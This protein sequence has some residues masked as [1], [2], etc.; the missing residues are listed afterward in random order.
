MN[1]RM[2]H[3][4]REDNDKALP[5]IIDRMRTV[6]QAWDEAAD[7]RAIFLTCYT[8]MTANML[9]A[10]DAREFDD[11]AW[12]DHLINR[13]AGYYFDALTAYD[14]DP[15]RSPRVW[16]L[17]HTTCRESQVWALQKLLLGI[18]AHINYDLVLTLDAMLGPEWAALTDAQ[19]ASR[20]R[21]YRQVNEVIGRTIDAVQDE[22]LADA[23]PFMR[24]VDLLMGPGDEL[25][26]S[27][28]LIRWRDHVWDYAVEL[29]E[30][31]DLEAREDVIRRMEAEA[32]RRATAIRSADGPT[33]FWELF[34]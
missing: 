28:L 33:L 24:A 11:P 5:P 12:V 27:R 22:V 32:M 13:F 14:D 30:A 21:D 23:M 10:V 25:V 4:P 16:Q 7:Q 2:S 34:R 29:V 15:A 17:A 8:M 18:N 31:A 20:S 1:G 26:L 6:S 19:R 3:Q 9:A